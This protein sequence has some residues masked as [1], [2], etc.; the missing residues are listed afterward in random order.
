MQ[1]IS[2]LMEEYVNTLSSPFD[3]FLDDHI[4]SSNFYLITDGSNSMGYCAIHKGKLIT[5]FYIKLKYINYAQDIFKAMLKEFT[6]E[7]AFVPTCDELFLSLALD[8]D[9]IVKKQAYFFKENK[10]FDERDKLYKN[11]VFRIA[12]RADIHKIEMVSGYFFDKLE[13]RVEKNEIFVFTE[14]DVLLGIGII[15]KGRVLKGFTS[16]GMFTNELYRQRGIGISIIL[17]LKKW[18]CD[19]NQIPICGC[20]YYNT[21][22]KRTLESAGFV[23]K[24][25]LLNIEFKNK[26]NLNLTNKE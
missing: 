12:N 26:M 17:Y 20:W 2:G 7:A 24:T 15:E 11:G 4:V 6:T 22:S 14:E 13:E 10:E 25:R 1:E 19:N 9:V 3:S 8:Q 18:C 21:N 16:I 5:Q 23:T